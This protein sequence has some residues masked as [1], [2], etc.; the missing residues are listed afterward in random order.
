M[1]N[2]NQLFR[3]LGL[4][5]EL[6][7]NA[8]ADATTP[9]SETSAPA[10]KSGSDILT[11]GAIVDGEFLK[12]D[13]D[14]IVSA[15]ADSGGGGGGGGVGYEFTSTA[16]VSV[17]RSV[18]AHE[19]DVGG[20]QI[21]ASLANGTDT[22][23]HTFRTIAGSAHSLYVRGVFITRNQGGISSGKVSSFMQLLATTGIASARIRWVDALHGGGWIVEQISGTGSTVSEGEDPE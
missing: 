2:A 23:T 21:D 12:R 18:T 15:E 4:P 10:L 1:S 17:N 3:S 16:S 6:A 14:T 22:E 11:I 7:A 19:Y 20:G 13:G 9:A 8:G 5:P